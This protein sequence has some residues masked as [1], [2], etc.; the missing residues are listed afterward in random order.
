MCWCQK[1]SKPG[2]TS[3]RSVDKRGECDDL[4]G[5]T[6]ERSAFLWRRLRCWVVWSFPAPSTPPPHCSGVKSSQAFVSGVA[7]PLCFL[8][9]CI[10]NYGATLETLPG[11]VPKNETVALVAVAVITS[12]SK[13]T[14]ELGCSWVEGAEGWFGRDLVAPYVLQVQ[15]P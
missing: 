9:L 11:W 15:T 5:S 7:L 3:T 12:S 13:L 10:C 1:K 8:Q 2:Q 4:N 6:Y 14:W